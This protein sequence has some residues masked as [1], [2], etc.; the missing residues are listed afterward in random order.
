MAGRKNQ[1][2]LHSLCEIEFLFILFVFCYFRVVL[3]IFHSVCRR[4]LRSFRFVRIAHVSSLDVWRNLLKFQAFR[5][6]ERLA[7]R[8]EENGKGKFVQG[9]VCSSANSKKVFHIFF[10]P[11]PPSL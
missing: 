6:G 1:S 3:I 8:R 7:T 4:A 10:H 5:L 9:R 11:L 2:A